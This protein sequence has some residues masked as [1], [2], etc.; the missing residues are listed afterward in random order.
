M[1]KKQTA[2]RLCT[3]FLSMVF[4]F[5][6]TG[7]GNN[8]EIE[9]LKNQLSE[10]DAELATLNKQLDYYT[11]ENDS[12]TLENEAV[13]TVIGGKVQSVTE[14]F[15]TLV[16]ISG[17]IGFS[18]WKKNDEVVSGENVLNVRLEGIER[19]VTFTAIYNCIGIMAVIGNLSND[20]TVKTINQFKN[21]INTDPIFK[22][23]YSY[24]PTN[25]SQPCTFDGN[26]GEDRF[27]IDEL[28]KSPDIYCYK[29]SNSANVISF[30][31]IFLPD[32][33]APAEKFDNSTTEEVTEPVSGEDEQTAQEPVNYDL[34]DEEGQQR[35]NYN[36]NDALVF[37]M[38]T[39][40]IDL[41]KNANVC[42][43]I[44]NQL[45]GT[46]SDTKKISILIKHS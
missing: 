8:A 39:Q 4:I 7:C 11:S 35:R 2:F 5:M 43:S 20:K 3:A 31:K 25:T 6:F 22:A 41:S 21:S 14:Q 9:N 46:L 12:Y 32:G 36:D 40:E 15:L 26:G 16:T 42:V 27:C 24:D 13:V 28:N 23:Y 37:W 33:V 10:K 38:N 29:L 18:V 34:F 17:K 19:D 44:S 30:F 45:A 1:T